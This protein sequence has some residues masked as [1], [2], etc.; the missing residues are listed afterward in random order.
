[1]KDAP[2]AV[3][4]ALALAFA[5]TTH[6]IEVFVRDQIETCDSDWQPRLRTHTRASALAASLCSGSSSRNSGDSTNIHIGC[7]FPEYIAG[8]PREVGQIGQVPFT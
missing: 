4:E 7:S 2:Q 1:M 5:R 3:I 8:I 6:G